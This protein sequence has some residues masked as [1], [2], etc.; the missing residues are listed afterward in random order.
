MV[1]IKTMQTTVKKI[2]SVTN[3]GYGKSVFGTREIELSGL[4]NWMLSEQQSALNFR[5]RS[6]TN[7][8]QSDWHLAGDPT[9]LIILT[10]VIE[11]QLRDGSSQQF[12]A[13]D[14]FIAEDY[15]IDGV[16]FDDSHGHCAQVI[17]QEVLEALHLKLDKR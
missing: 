12:A 11:I 1:A 7:P 16:V 17:G 2:P 10:G 9:L 15:L 3:D 8:Y 5:L 14:L 13:G 4:S 6:S